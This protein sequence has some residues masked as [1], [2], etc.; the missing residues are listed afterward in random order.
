MLST[1]SKQSKVKYYH[2]NIDIVLLFGMKEIYM[3]H[4]LYKNQ[5]SKNQLLTI[6]NLKKELQQ[7]AIQN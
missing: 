2:Y 5:Y 7:K 6:A 4:I 1:K 3:P